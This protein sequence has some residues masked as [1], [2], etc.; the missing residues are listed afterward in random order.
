MPSIL[1]ALHSY[2]K[3]FPFHLCLNY[4][5]SQHLYHYGFVSCNVMWMLFISVLA[6]VRFFRLTPASITHVLML[7][8]YC[9]CL[10]TCLL[11]DITRCS[12]IVL[13]FPCPCSRPSILQRNPSLFKIVFRNHY[14]DTRYAHCY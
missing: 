3:L 4:L 11:P 14:L 5:T 7:C 9:F 13:Y 8:I 10:S 6:I 2:G 12:K 1:V